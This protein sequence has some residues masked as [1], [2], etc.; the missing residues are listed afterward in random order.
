MLIQHFT[1]SLHSTTHSGGSHF[2]QRTLLFPHVSI[3]RQWGCSSFSP[4][5]NSPSKVQST[6]DLELG[7]VRGVHMSTLQ[8]GKER[9]GTSRGKYW[10]QHLA[11]LLAITSLADHICRLLGLFTDF[12]K[13]SSRC[14]AKNCTLY[15]FLKSPPRR[16]GS[17][18]CQKYFISTSK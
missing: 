6:Q 5:G 11:T 10:L 13:N 15:C 2:Q 4:R 17:L 12:L 18:P 9:S 8:R 14:A 3:R 1:L 7:H 16:A